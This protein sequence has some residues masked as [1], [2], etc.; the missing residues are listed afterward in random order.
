MVVACEE[1]NVEHD[2]VLVHLPS[3]EAKF[4]KRANLTFEDHCD[5]PAWLPEGCSHA[6]KL[7]FGGKFKRCFFNPEGVCCW[8]KRN[9]QRQAEPAGAGK[10]GPAESEA[11]PGPAAIIGSGGDAKCV[12]CLQK[13]ATHIVVPCGHQGL[14]EVCTGFSHCHCPYCRGPV[15][16]IMKVF[17]VGERDEPALMP[18]M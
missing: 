4:V 18:A 2:R 16:K 7:T 17:A 10:P 6:R 11:A 14:C 3:G 1:W 13:T 12:I 15:E 9:F 5:P 8:S